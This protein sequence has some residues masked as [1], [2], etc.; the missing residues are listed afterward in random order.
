MK[1]I[2]L[3]FISLSLCLSTLFAQDVKPFKNGDRVVF[4]G[5]SITC[6]G[7]YH[8][9]IWL[10]YMTRFPE[11]RIDVFN[12]GIGGDIAEMIYARLDKVFEHNPTVLTLTF[13]MNDTGYMNFMD[14]QGKE[15]GDA[16]L[17]KTFTDYKLLEEAYKKYKKADKILIGGS[18]YDET[19]GG[20]NKSPFPG[21]N[22]R[23]QIIG[24][25]LEESAKKNKWAFV[26]FNQPMVDINA[27]EQKVDSAFSFCGWDRVHPTTDGHMVM[28]YLFL[29]AQGFSGKPVADIV[30]D[31]KTGTIDL[32]ENCNI[33]SLQATPTSVT[34]N[35]KANSLPYP[36]DGKRYDN[37]T[38]SQAD[39]LKV[40]PFM[41]EMNREGLAIKGL[42]NGYYN[43]KIGNRV[44]KRYTA[45]ELARGINMAELKDTPQYQKALRIMEMNERRWRL[46]REMREF[47]WIEYNVMRKT[48]MLWKCDEAAVDTL[49]KYSPKDIFVKM[50]GEYWLKFRSKAV[51]DNCVKEQQ[52]LTE[53]IYQLNKPEEL[54]IVIEKI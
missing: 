41:E 52:E 23:I 6:G 2:L 12:E 54:A 31:S 17:E 21:K 5:N 44:I 13:G 28:A 24:R 14:E 35:Y 8:S 20:P 48:G 43:L 38:K 3:S 16:R 46:E 22:E 4:V 33:S 29:K 40:I 26:D 32:A 7:H 27:R 15:R 36:I 53:K 25:M 51:R 42:G 37:E 39:A 19:T 10:Y 45:Q 47:F 30:I 50:N 11:M 9:Y 18:P 49:L 1:T 34:F